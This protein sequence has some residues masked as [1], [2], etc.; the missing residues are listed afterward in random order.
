MNR[1]E[2]E[3]ELASSH[4]RGESEDANETLHEW[5]LRMFR[6]IDAGM[7]SVINH[8]NTEHTNEPF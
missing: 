2:H 3:A 1:Q 7:K 6:E 8:D 4:A 5:R